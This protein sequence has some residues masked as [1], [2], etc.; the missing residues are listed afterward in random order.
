MILVSRKLELNFGIRLSCNRYFA[1]RPNFELHEAGSIETI[2]EPPP[3]NTSDERGTMVLCINRRQGKQ[4]LE[5]LAHQL[6]RWKNLQCIVCLVNI[7][8]A[9]F[10]A[11][12]IGSHDLSQG[13]L[14]PFVVVVSYWQLF[15]AFEP[16]AKFAMLTITS[17][18]GVTF[19][20]TGLSSWFGHHL[21]GFYKRVWLSLFLIFDIA[22]MGTQIAGIVVLSAAK[23]PWNCRGVANGMC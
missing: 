17:Q 10:L 9:T 4:P 21:G 12:Y 1:D 15:T 20:F 8:S 6:Y 5:H 18:S 14:P 22:C 23:L 11:G 13:T 19:V 16:A 7:I 2:P 3:P